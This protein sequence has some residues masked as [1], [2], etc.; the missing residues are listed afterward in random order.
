LSVSSASSRLA[1]QDDLVKLAQLLNRHD[2]NLDGREKIWLRVLAGYAFF[3]ADSVERGAALTWLRAEPLDDE[4]GRALRMTPG[5]EGADADVWQINDLSL[6]R[7]RDLCSL[8]SY[9]RPFLFCFDQTEFYGSDKVLVEA[10][11]NCIEELYATIPNQLTVV[12]ANATNWTQDIRPNLKPANQARFSTAIELEGINEVQ[13]RE[14]LAERLKDFQLKASSISQF[15]EATWL[16]SQ[17]SSQPNIGVRHLL[18]RAAERLRS[19]PMAEVF[20][21]ATA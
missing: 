10:L 18:V 5:S 13:G 2:I 7:L 16:S 11:G 14:L 6:T 1:K 21:I 8:S 15:L 20:A 3:P 12:T 17:F 9:Y 4:Q 19:P